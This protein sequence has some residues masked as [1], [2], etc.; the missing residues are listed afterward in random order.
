ML[1]HTR[2]FTTALC[3]CTLFLGQLCAQ[4][5][6]VDF[7]AKSDPDSRD[8]D[9]LRRW[10]R[11]KRFVTM[12]EI[13]GDLSLSGEVRTEFQAINERRDGVQQRDNPVSLRIS[14]T[15]NPCTHG[16]SK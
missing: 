5:P 2:F 10:L 16:T 14:R 13:G 4:A 8:M 9:A 7:D 11:D 12:K 6:D 1:N 15:Q 3:A